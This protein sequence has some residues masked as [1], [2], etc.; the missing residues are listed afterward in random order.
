MMRDLRMTDNLNGISHTKRELKKMKEF[1]ENRREGREGIYSNQF[2]I[3]ASYIHS[4]FEKDFLRGAY[5]N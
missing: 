1:S 2:K 5:C 4:V 3:Q